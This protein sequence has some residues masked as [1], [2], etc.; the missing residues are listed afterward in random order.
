MDVCVWKLQQGGHTIFR[1]LTKGMMML[2]SILVS[3]CHIQ[4]ANKGHDNDR[5][6]AVCE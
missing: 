3:C 2:V 4:A 6:H 5:L 1:Q